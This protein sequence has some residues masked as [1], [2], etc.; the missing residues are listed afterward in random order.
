[1]FTITLT[2]V[3]HVTINSI[4]WLNHRKVNLIF[5]G[6]AHTERGADTSYRDDYSGWTA[7][8]Q[9]SVRGLRIMVQNPY[10]V[11]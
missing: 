1:M 9:Y 8:T 11:V 5:T 4:N 10:W 6:F 2:L 7:L 3:I